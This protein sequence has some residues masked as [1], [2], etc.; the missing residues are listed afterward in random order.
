VKRGAC[1]GAREDWTGLFDAAEH[2]TL[3]LDEIGELALESQPKLFAAA[4]TRK[5]IAA[6]NRSLEEALR[7]HQFRPHLSSRLNLLRIELPPLTWL[8]QC[9]VVDRSHLTAHDPRR[10]SR[11][12]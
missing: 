4:V 5:V 8:A 1:T 9:S 10:R 2:G 12:R 6:T 7:D 3:F 11:R